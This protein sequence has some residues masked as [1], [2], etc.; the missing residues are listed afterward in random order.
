MNTL[1]TMNKRM[2]GCLVVLVLLLSACGAQD[3]DLNVVMAGQGSITSPGGVDCEASCTAS[4]K[5]NP[6]FIGNKI[7]KLTATAAPGYE[8]IGWNHRSCTAAETC[9]L[10]FSGI[11]AD[12]LICS[13]GL[14][15][16]EETIKPVFVDSSILL[17]AGWSESAVCAAFSSGEVQCWP[18]SANDEVGQVPPLNNPQQVAV[19]GNAACA[20]VDE[21]VQ[22]WGHPNLIPNDAPLLY[23]PMEMEM[24][25]ARVCVID[26]EGLKCWGTAGEIS[27]PAVVNPTNLRKQYVETPQ[28]SGHQFCVDDD[29]EPLCW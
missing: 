18:R 7:V 1:I 11:C 19:A 28:W 2:K 16:F 26:Q 21:G 8:F 25:T 13:T 5:I 14:V 22:C 15:Y 24:L 27:T 29:G 10:E 20:Q 6:P 23:P 9:D 17:D 3:V 12:Q 4:V